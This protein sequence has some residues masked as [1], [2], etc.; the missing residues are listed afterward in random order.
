MTAAGKC[1]PTSG[2]GRKMDPAFAEV[3]NSLTTALAAIA[4]AFF[5]AV[6]D[7]SDPHTA[8]VPPAVP[9]LAAL[10]IF[11]FLFG[12]VIRYVFAGY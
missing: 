3:V 7:A 11:L 8:E 5:A 6:V 12:R 9:Y 4:V 1:Q 10:G 2:L